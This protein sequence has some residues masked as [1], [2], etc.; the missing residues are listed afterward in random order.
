MSV[1]H[2][3]AQHHRPVQVPI[4]GGSVGC[5]LTGRRQ[6]IGACSPC[7]HLQGSLSGPDP[8]LLCDVLATREPPRTG[9]RSRRAPRHGWRI[10]DVS[11]PESDESE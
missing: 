3:G 10:F 8:V 7:P 9:L 4:V 1:V 5:L 6:P 11:W 2:L